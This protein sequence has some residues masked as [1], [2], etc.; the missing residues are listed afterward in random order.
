MKKL[1]AVTGAS[2]FIGS[3]VVRAC[4][5]RG[6]A[7]RSLVRRDTAGGAN[8]F[9]IGDIDSDTN[10]QNAL[11]GV[12]CIVHCAGRAHVL[13]ERNSDPLAEFRRINRDGTLNLAEQAATTGVKRLIFLSSIGVMGSTTDGRA[14]F[15][16]SDTPQPMMDYAISK[17]EAERGLQEI[18]T[19]TGLEVVILRPPMVY[20]P[21]APGN[22][23]RLVRALVKGWPL[24]LGSVSSNRRS[25]IG[26][27][28]LVDLIVTCIE[29]PAAASQTFLACDGEDVSTVDLLRRM[30]VALKKSPR[31]LPFPVSLI[32]VGAGVLG[33]AT[34]AQSL[35][36]SL[37]VDGDKARQMLGWEPP[38]DL[39]EGLRLAVEE[40]LSE[41]PV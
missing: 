25:Y 6:V 17:L 13:I 4:E 40:Y 16:E 22:F 20:G 9:E 24:P 39:N 38:L 11:E 27:Q 35:C 36:A 33:K 12:E 5:K 1:V 34:L 31:L 30:G 8:S 2:G 3:T 18:A 10:W 14:P 37:Q 15:S 41:T 26:I 29:H 21:G 28:N 19:R 7:V 23:A 32:K